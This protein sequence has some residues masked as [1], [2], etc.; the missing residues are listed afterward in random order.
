MDRQMG[1]SEV[2]LFVRA[3]LICKNKSPLAQGTR[4]DSLFPLQMG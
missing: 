4:Q 2:M 3:E 1:L